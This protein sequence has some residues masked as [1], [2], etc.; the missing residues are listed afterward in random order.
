[1]RP[2][3]LAKDLETL[4]KSMRDIGFSISNRKKQVSAAGNQDAYSQ[5]YQ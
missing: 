5:H 4:R 3:C 1:M 2:A